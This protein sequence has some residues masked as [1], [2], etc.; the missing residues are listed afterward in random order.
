MGGDMATEMN[1]KDFA[2]EDV[3]LASIKVNDATATFL[4]AVEEATQQSTYINKMALDK[5]K[6][7]FCA[8]K[9]DWEKESKDLRKIQRSIDEIQ[10]FCAENA[11]NLKNTK[12]SQS[13]FIMQTLV[14]VVIPI[15]TLASG[16]T[17]RVPP[18]KIFN[19]IVYVCGIDGKICEVLVMLLCLNRDTVRFPEAMAELG[20]YYDS[21]IAGDIPQS[22]MHYELVGLH[23]MYLLAQ[24]KLSE[25]SI[26]SARIPTQVRNENPYISL[27]IQL[28]QYMNVG[29]YN[30]IFLLKVNVPSVYYSNF[31]EIFLTTVR[32]EIANCVEKSNRKL[33]LKDA[34]RSL[35][36][37]GPK[38]ENEALVYGK[39]RNWEVKNNVFHFSVEKEEE[40]VINT[41]PMIAQLIDYA[42]HLEMIV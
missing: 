17:A 13:L 31:M 41:M 18:W 35:F 42:K 8:L 33:S 10:E 16:G 5:L 11:D 4:K 28:E 3:L 1:I 30:K 36:F 26:E 2:L 34:A 19:G 20:H 40:Q 24:N 23:L 38:A 37:E 27:P 9:T 39:S 15:S 32:N 21:K 6:S 14:G 12:D 25:F 7:L 22:E 29:L